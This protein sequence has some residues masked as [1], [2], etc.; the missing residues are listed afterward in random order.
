MPSFHENMN[1]LNTIVTEFF[2]SPVGT[3]FQ[4]FLETQLGRLV[5]LFERFIA[6]PVK[7][8]QWIGGVILA[9]IL[10]AT[11]LTHVPSST[12]VQVTAQHAN[13]GTIAT[14]MATAIPKATATPRPTSTP[15]IPADLP[16]LTPP[17]ATGGKATIGGTLDAFFRQYP[18]HEWSAPLAKFI[19]NC[20][21]QHT[22]Y[23]LSVSADKGVDGKQ[24]VWTLDENAPIGSPWN[25]NLADKTCFAW[26]PSDAQ[27]IAEVPFKTVDGFYLIRV[28]FQSSQLA[29][30]FPADQ[31]SDETSKDFPPPLV[32]P[33]TFSVL[34]FMTDNNF[35]GP[36]DGCTVGLGIIN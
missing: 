31:F 15:D 17:L 13:V 29:T 23:C 16:V 34:Y 7:A 22:A 11:I 27:Q 10:V 19:K 25:R 4:T 30:I 12:D 6:R 14:I 35:T 20:N 8:A 28:V 3:S 26:N 9:S 1:R 21:S 18:D 5:S 2:A 24:Y 36:I 32:A 33:G